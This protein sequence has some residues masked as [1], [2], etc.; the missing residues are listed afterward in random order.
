MILSV[1]VVVTSSTLRMRYK[2]MHLYAYRKKC[3]WDGI[4]SLLPVFY[5]F[6]YPR[7]GGPAIGDLR[8]TK[9]GT[10]EGGDWYVRRVTW[11]G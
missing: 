5:M 7:F 8:A 9:N 3:C 10:Q 4:A 1:V 6:D 2:S 11:S